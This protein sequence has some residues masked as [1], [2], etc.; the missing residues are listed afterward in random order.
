MK[1]ESGF[2]EKDAV[3]LLQSYALAVGRYAEEVYCPER[4]RVEDMLDSFVF[5]ERLLKSSD[6]GIR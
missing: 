6:G 4:A 5:P 3:E 2:F 1:E